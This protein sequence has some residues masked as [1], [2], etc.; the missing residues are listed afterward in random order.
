MNIPTFEN[1][2]IANE[3][4]YWSDVLLRMWID[5]FNELLAHA[6]QQG[7]DVP[8]Q[9]TA[10]RNFIEPTAPN[11]RLLWD[12]NTNELYVRKNDG[13]FHQIVTL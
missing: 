2:K 4:G 10:N 5:L 9:T 1:A 3:E 8:Q 13:A 11:G 7:L 12:T 6:G